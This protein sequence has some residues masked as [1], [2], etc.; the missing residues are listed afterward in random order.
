[1]K[2]LAL[3]FMFRGE[4]GSMNCYLRNL[5]FDVSARIVMQLFTEKVLSSMFSLKIPF[6]VISLF[7]SLSR[8]TFSCVTSD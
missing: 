7:H 1:M 4:T 6:L 2:D 5:I 8:T 3:Y